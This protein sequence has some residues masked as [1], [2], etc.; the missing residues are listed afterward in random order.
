M[1]QRDVI[2]SVIQRGGVGSDTNAIKDQNL[3]SIDMAAKDRSDF[4]IFD[5]LSTTPYFG[6]VKNDKL[7]EWA[8]TIPGPYTEKVGKKAKEYG[9]TILVPMFEKFQGKYYNSVAIIG[10][11]GNLIK[12]TLPDG[13]TVHRYSK[14]HVPRIEILDQGLIDEKYYFSP[15]PGFSVFKTP[16]ATIGTCICFDRRF[17]E[18]C[19]CL[20]LGGA[21]IIFLPTDAPFHALQSEDTY[22]SELRSRASENQVVLVSANKAGIEEFEGKKTNFIG[23]SCV[24]GPGGFIID[25]P[26][27]PDK[28]A[29][30]SV[31]VDLSEVEKNR[32]ILP[33]F[34]QRKPEL[35]GRITQK[36]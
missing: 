9:C 27:S 14:V 13:S 3:K 8:E 29:I 28:P 5:E 16:K 17:P 2:I 6:F 36:M 26:A 30:L 15:G 34:V 11:D 32:R 4:I 7:F 23:R 19:R 20:A 25:K 24:I 10:P 21:E 12:G 31:K 35:Y 18:S 33:L 1:P 22:Y